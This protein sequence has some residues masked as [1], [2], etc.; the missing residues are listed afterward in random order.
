[1]TTF[2]VWAPNASHVDLL[3]SEQARPMEAQPGGWWA[4]YA[5]EAEP[6]MDYAYSLD[7]GPPLPDPRSRWQ[8]HGVHGPSRLVDL[9]SF[10]WSDA[11]WNAPPLRR[12][13]IY[14]LHVGTF[15]PEGTFDGVV[16][17]LDYL[18]GLGVTHV[19]L[20]PVAQFPGRH[21]WGYDGV[22]LYAPHQAYGG[23]A[24]LQ[25]LV[26]A[27]HQKGLAVLLDVVYNH[28]GPDGNYLAQFGPYFTDHY[29][30]P[31]GDAVNLDGPGSDEVR[32]FFIDNALMWLRDY[33]LDGLRIDAIH[34]LYDHSAVHFLTQLGEEAAA[35]EKELG[36]RLV[37]IAESDLND[38][39]VVRPVAAG[40]YGMDAQWSDD[41]HHAL[42][43]ALTGERT[44]YYADFG[45]LADLATALRQ[46]YVYA[47]RFSTFRNRTHGAL[48]TTV[49]GGHNL[50]LLPGDRFLGYL[51]NHDQ[52]GNR[53]QGERISHLVDAE[54]AK[55][56][57]ALVLTAP[58]VPM[59]F[60]G[61][62]WGASSPFLFFADHEDAALAEAVRAGR[63]Q[64]FAAFGWA[65]DQVPD[66]QDEE[67][68]RRSK[69]DWDEWERHPHQGL[70]AWYRRLIRLRRE[71]PALRSYRLDSVRVD[72][73]E[74]A[75]WLVLHRPPLVIVCNFADE[76]Q[77]IPLSG[78][79]GYRLLLSS[80]PGDMP[81]ATR[82]SLALPGPS[83]AILERSAPQGRFP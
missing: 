9:D 56:G 58:F 21:G 64:E 76:A 80:R 3:L 71:H 81:A 54:R 8:P 29:R 77:T 12:A 42:H 31:W 34:A 60:Q 28:L 68:F 35:L 53:A 45:A 59:L 30:T 7:G 73:D 49:A 24:G 79:A 65:P 26:N 14:E 23:P 62:E 67:S 52:V 40:G 41:F 78:A 51:Q 18:R 72:Y 48:P 19:E 66:P 75:R 61:E 63:Q 47:G 38:P 33:H 82:D 50:R 57:A 15:T 11:R 55:V 5:P 6:G 36:R 16:G 37:L 44:G 46:A 32:R 74:D 2:R 39:R 27:C 43:A 25:R 69:L 17:R 83:V 70:M 10:V 4:L 13:V 1:M 20:L 22:D